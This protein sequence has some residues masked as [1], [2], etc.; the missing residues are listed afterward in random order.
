MNA[1]GNGNNNGNPV[2]TPGN[3]NMAAGSKPVTQ[4]NPVRTTGNASPAPA[5]TSKNGANGKTG[6]TSSSS[7]AAG[8]PS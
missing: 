8:N 1:G 4:N 3:V 7:V 6:D 5:P 2:A